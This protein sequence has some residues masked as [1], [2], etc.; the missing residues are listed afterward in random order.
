MQPVSP[1]VARYGIMNY[2]GIYE[3]YKMLKIR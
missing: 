2:Y 3:L 1:P